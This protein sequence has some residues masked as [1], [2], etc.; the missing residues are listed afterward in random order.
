MREY[1][2]Y[3][4]TKSGNLIYQYNFDYFKV[5][6]LFLTYCSTTR[7]HQK[8]AYVGNLMKGKSFDHLIIHILDKL[9]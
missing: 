1:A 8:L 3:S 5:K 2:I 6:V 7:N 4:N 9:E